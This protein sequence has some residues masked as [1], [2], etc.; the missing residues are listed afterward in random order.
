MKRILKKHA[1]ICREISIGRHT[2]NVHSQDHL[3][4]NLAQDRLNRQPHHH[5][6]TCHQRGHPPLLRR[7]CVHLIGQALPSL[8]GPQPLLR[9]RHH[10]HHCLL[11]CPELPS[12][13]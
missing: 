11:P 7:R 5:Y 6:H 9:R 10:H 3:Y 13:R 4:R 8:Q 1:T 2:Y 12:S